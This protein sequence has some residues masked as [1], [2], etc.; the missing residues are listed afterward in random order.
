MNHSIKVKEVYPLDDMRLKVVFENNVVK[1][2][3]VKQLLNEY[4]DMFKTLLDNPVLFNDVC[5]DSGGYAVSWSSDID[6]PECELWEGGEV[7]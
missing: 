6:I 4:F 3:D 1:T 7:S 5:V 2:Y